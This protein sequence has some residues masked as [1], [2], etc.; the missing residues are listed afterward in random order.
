ML[1]NDNYSNDVYKLGVSIVTRNVTRTMNHIATSADFSRVV[2][3]W[4]ENH[5][6]FFTIRKIKNGKSGTNSK[7][8]CFINLHR[9]VRTSLVAVIMLDKCGT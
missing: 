2:S 6:R 3:A 1:S 9:L 8:A 5:A 7:L 4:S